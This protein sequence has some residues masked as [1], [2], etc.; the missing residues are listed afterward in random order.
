MGGVGVGSLTVGSLSMSLFG[1]GRSDS[2]GSSVF[3]STVGCR[4][5]L[6]LVDPEGRCEFVDDSFTQFPS[7]VGRQSM[8]SLFALNMSQFCYTYN[9]A[10]FTQ[11]HSS[12]QISAKNTSHLRSSS[13]SSN[14]D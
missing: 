14:L 13:A 2:E 1:V 7:L 11:F 8:Q 6:G 4:M 5:K 12:V 10:F 9:R 3:T